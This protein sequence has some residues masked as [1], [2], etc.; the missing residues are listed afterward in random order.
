MHAGAKK[1]FINITVSPIALMLMSIPMCQGKLGEFFH[2]LG[3]S[4]TLYC[5]EKFGP[6]KNGPGGPFLVDK[7][8]SGGTKFGYQNWSGPTKN[9][10]V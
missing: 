2:R 8:W 9:G 4:Y 5:N 3:V 10:P 1:S 6:G 7:I